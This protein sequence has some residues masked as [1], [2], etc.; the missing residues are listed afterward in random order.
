MNE[1]DRLAAILGNNQGNNGVI[2]RLAVNNN[3]MQIPQQ[4]QQTPYQGNN[5]NG[6][7]QNTPFENY[8]GYNNN[9]SQGFHNSNYFFKGRPVSSKEEARVAQIDLDGSLWVFMDVSHG[10]IYTKQILNDASS[11]FR[12]YVLQQEEDDAGNEYVTKNDL[13]KVVQY[14][15]SLIPAAAAQVPAQEPPKSDKA[16]LNF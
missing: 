8:M 12:T 4:R 6:L 5:M 1:Q 15:Q 13:S 11:D 7:L 14:F 9:G 10:R 16:P 2:P 3:Q